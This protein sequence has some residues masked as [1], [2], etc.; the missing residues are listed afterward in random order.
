MLRNYLAYRNDEM[1]VDTVTGAIGRVGNPRRRI[2]NIC[3]R[4]NSVRAYTARKTP[5]HV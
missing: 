4:T 2:N 3:S 5:E 1:F